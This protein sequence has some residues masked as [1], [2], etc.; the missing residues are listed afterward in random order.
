MKKLMIIGDAGDN[1]LGQALTVVLAQKLSVPVIGAT[2]DSCLGL[3]LEE[4]PSAVLLVSPDDKDK[5][6][7]KDLQLT[8][9]EFK[10]LSASYEPTSEENFQMPF[11]LE[12]FV[13]WLEEKM[14]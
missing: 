5:V 1:W 14:G 13:A 8:G 3:F 12:K 6:C 11:D 10:T 9:E 7:L 4:N 2:H